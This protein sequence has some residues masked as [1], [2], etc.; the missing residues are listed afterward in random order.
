MQTKSRI[1]FP[2]LLSAVY[3]ALYCCDLMVPGPYL[4]ST[5]FYQHLLTSHELKQYFGESILLVN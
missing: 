2:M 1:H 5:N 3:T 4:V